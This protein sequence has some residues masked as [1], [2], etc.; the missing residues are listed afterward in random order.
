MDALPVSGSMLTQSTSAITDSAAGAT[1]IATGV[2][3]NN[4]Y[5]GVGPDGER[6]PTLLEIARDAGKS[7]GLVEDSDVTNATTG[8]FAAHVKDRDQRRQIA[9]SYLYD[10][11]PDVILGGG[12]QFWYPRG[13][14]G[15]IPN[16]LPGDREPRQEEP[17]RRGAGP[18]LSVR[19]RR[20]GR[21]RAHR[22]EG[23]RPR[24]GDPVRPRAARR[25]RPQERSPL[26]AGGDARREGDR[27]PEPGSR[28][29]S[30]SRSTSTRSTSAATPATP[31]W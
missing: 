24:P 7:T 22:A 9:S 23:A 25:L 14:P 26:R 5:I 20:R 19:L 15:A 6:L 2:K 21:R 27:D 29:A 11:K 1:A 30:S 3:T 8:S 17:R 10:T 18:R 28:T 12:E 4:G 13:T 16:V 31:D